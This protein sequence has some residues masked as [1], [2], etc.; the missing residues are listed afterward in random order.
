MR[1]PGS[2]AVNPMARGANQ[3]GKK[4]GRVVEEEL[5]EAEDIQVDVEGAEDD[6][7]DEEEEEM[8]VLFGCCKC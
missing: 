4:R 7:E 3:W 1:V 5:E 6:D 2:R 8:D